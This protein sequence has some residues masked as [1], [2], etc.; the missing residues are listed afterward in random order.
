[1]FAEEKEKRKEIMN[2][3]MIWVASEW[4]QKF[5]S[6]NNNNDGIFCEV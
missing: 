4:M 3:I 2:G 5:H 1:M 6:I